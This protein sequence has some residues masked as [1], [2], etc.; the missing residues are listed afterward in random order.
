[1][2]QK[3]MFFGA[4][5]SKAFDFPVTGQILPLMIDGI[6][7]YHWKGKSW[8][9]K[10]DEPNQQLYI[11]W[12]Q[13]LLFRLSPGIPRFFTDKNIDRK[14][15]ENAGLPLVTDLLSQLDHLLA[16]AQDIYDWNF[17]GTYT[18]S[19][20]IAHIGSRI[21]LKLLKT[22]FEWGIISAIGQTKAREIVALNP[23]FDYIKKINRRGKRDFITTITTNYDPLLEWNFLDDGEAYYAC[24][25]VDYGFSWRDVDDIGTIRPRPSKPKFAVFKLHGSF[26]WLKCERCGYIYVNPTSSIYTLAYSNVKEDRNTC[27]C[28]HWPLKPVIVTP[29]YIR[30]VFD[31][32]LHEIWKASLEALRKADEWILVGYSLPNEDFNIKSLF[33]RAYAGRKKKPRVT[34]VQYKDEARGRYENFF[35]ENQVDYQNE[36]LE[37]FVKKYIKPLR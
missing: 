3:V 2:A 33:L 30:S 4:G 5:L 8:L 35:E 24:D 31:T 28:G 21:D 25:R 10:E 32:N 7:Q 27:H 23:L 12:L 16:S 19:V 26:D 1:M 15:L 34:V 17:N 18:A 14:G 11:S 29:S 36:G 6:R 9:Y 13:L 37:P 20:S 22:I